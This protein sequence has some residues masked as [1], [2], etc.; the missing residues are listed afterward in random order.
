M[1]AMGANSSK[2]ALSKIAPLKRQRRKDSTAVQ[3]REV[4]NLNIPAAADQLHADRPAGEAFDAPLHRGHRLRS[5]TVWLVEY[6]AGVREQKQRYWLYDYRT[7]VH[8]TLKKKTMRF[9]DLAEFIECYN[10]SNRHKRK[11]T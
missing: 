3:A 1:A 8:H 5:V 7:N 4:A 9:D 10:P 6:F 11:E 2:A